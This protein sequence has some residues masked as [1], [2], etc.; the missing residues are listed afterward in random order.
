MNFLTH[1][2]E[3]KVRIC[4]Q[5]HTCEGDLAGIQPNTTIDNAIPIHCASSGQNFLFKQT[6]ILAREPIYLR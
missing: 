4:E 2:A 6:K 1:E 3:L 5:E